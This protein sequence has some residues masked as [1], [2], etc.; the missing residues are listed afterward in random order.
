[1]VFVLFLVVGDNFFYDLVGV[2][3]LLNCDVWCDWYGCSGGWIFLCLLV[4]YVGLLSWFVEC[5][6]CGWW[7]WW[8]RGWMGR[9]SWWSV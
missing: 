7:C 4:G 2:I 5:L 1:M 3:L 6:D 9:L 8:L